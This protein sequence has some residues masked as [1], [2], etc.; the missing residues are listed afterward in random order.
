MKKICLVF[1]LV[2]AGPLYAD[3]LNEENNS[4]LMST[5]LD[6]ELEEGFFSGALRRCRRWIREEGPLETKLEKSDPEKSR[7]IHAIRKHDPLTLQ[8]LLKTAHLTT[9]EKN[10]FLALANRITKIHENRMAQRINRHDALR[11]GTNI[12]ALSVAGM[13]AIL[14]MECRGV[15]LI[16]P[17]LF[18]ASNTLLFLGVGLHQLHEGLTKQERLSKLAKAYAIEAMIDHA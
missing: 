4:D 13:F 2:M 9:Q 10:E 1:G 7:I 17:G 5:T 8:E 3:G 11:L 15:N 16:F 12:F 14:S 18:F 6:A